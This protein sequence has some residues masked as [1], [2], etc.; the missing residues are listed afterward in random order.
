[1]S[2]SSVLDEW[3]EF[4]LLSTILTVGCAKPAKNLFA[5]A[6][7]LPAQSAVQTVPDHQVLSIVYM[8]VVVTVIV[9]RQRG[10]PRQS[11]KVAFR[12]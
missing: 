5:V 8:E 9:V 7:I 10:L 1:M 3:P 12:T 2:L 4:V 11:R 6:S